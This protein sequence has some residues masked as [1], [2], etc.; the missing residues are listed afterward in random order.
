MLPWKW[1]CVVYA[2]VFRLFTI[3]YCAVFLW[4]LW[5]KLGHKNTLT[6]KNFTR[7]LTVFLPRLFFPLSLARL[8]NFLP[9]G[10]Q[11]PSALDHSGGGIQRSAVH[12]HRTFPWAD[13]CVPT[14]CSHRRGLG[15]RTGSPGCYHWTQRWRTHT[16]TQASHGIPFAINLA[17]QIL[18]F[19]IKQ[20]IPECIWAIHVLLRSYLEERIVQYR[21]TGFILSL[22]HY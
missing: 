12:G 6:Q 9:L 5:S 15:G 19:P 1:G 18:T 11:G 2:I 16:Y 17:T 20:C 3:S 4:A 13:L 10:Q 22:F 7:I 8:P 14:H 21:T